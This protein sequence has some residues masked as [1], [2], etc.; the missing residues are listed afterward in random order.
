MNAF[1]LPEKLA[2]PEITDDWKAALPDVVRDLARRWGLHVGRP[3]QPGGST[4]W[5][6]PATDLAG[7][8]LVLKVK[9]PHPD[10]VDEGRALRV[11]DGDGAVRRLDEHVTDHSIALLLE[12][13]EPGTTLK[14]VA[15][16]PEQDVVVAGLLRRLRRHQATDEP[17]RPLEV[18]C[19]EWADEFEELH[20]AQPGYID[21]G[22]AREGTLLYRSL[23]ASAPTSVMLCADLHA[24]NI[25]SAQRE[26]WLMTDP[27]PHIGDPTFDVLQHILNCAGRLQQDPIGLIQR[28]A[29]LLDLDTERLRLWL[30]ARCVIESFWQRDFD[31][32]ELAVRLRP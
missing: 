14:D 32:R 18:M 8:R 12:R 24:E 21:P 16:E 11:W 9:W 2:N 31:V 10:V 15:D 17:F 25:L 29:G 6:A 20:A 3:F 4:S 7:R 28:M 30:F 1:E 19:N 13:C 5:V 27:M 23:P 26:P 22:L